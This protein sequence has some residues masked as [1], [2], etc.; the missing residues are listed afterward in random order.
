[1]LGTRQREG[2]RLVGVT[3]ADVA[4]MQLMLDA[5]VGHFSTNEEVKNMLAVA[6]SA[7]RRYVNL[8]E[9]GWHQLESLYGK[10]WK[11]ITVFLSGVKYHC[12]AAVS[13][14]ADR[15]MAATH[16]ITSISYISFVARRAEVI[17][18]MRT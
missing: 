5:A 18:V 12:Y 16:S 15:P 6:S 9:E 1:M 8:V 2:V 4:D 17:E 3:D 14:S 7:S 13:G 10:Q 11:H